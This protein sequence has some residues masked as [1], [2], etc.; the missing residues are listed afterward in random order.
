MS[1]RMITVGAAQ[2]GPIAASESRADVVERLLAHMREAHRRGCDL[3]VYP[4]LTLTTFFPR[5]FTEDQGEIDKWF[6]REMPSPATQPLFDEAKRLKIGFKLGYA[7]LVEEAG[8]LRRFN[9]AIMVDK[10][11]QIIGKYRKVHLPG[12]SEHEPWRAFQHLEKRY[13]ET[14][15]LG[16]RVFE[17]FGG[18]MGM[19]ICNDRR[20]PETWRVLGL[21]GAE[22]VALG[23]N[24]PVHNPPA[25]EHDAFGLFHNQI[26]MQSAA[27]QNGLWIVAVAKCGD[28]EGVPMIAGTQIIAPSGATVAT[29]GTEDDELITAICDL[30]MAKSYKTSVFNFAR[31]REIDHYGLITATTGVV[32]PAEGEAL[33]KKLRQG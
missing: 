11:G 32:S 30:D 14:G 31:H 33:E 24:T 22:L 23:Y 16:F 25:P 1:E 3:V 2:M 18:H 7:E 19:C 20:W 17:G 29:T 5:W 12:H 4:E 15:D 10:N 21:Q 28:E 13:F 26:V 27:Y 9:T 8:T 6:E